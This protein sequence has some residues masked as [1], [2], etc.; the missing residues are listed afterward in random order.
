MPPLG[1]ELIDEDG[2]VAVQTLVDAPGPK[3]NIKCQEAE[4][5]IAQ[6][7]N[8][9]HVRL[10]AIHHQLDTIVLRNGVS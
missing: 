5:V 7:R 2:L 10:E 3:R 8:A 9:E 6:N 4:K 1:T